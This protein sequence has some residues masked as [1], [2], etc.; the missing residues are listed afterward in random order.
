MK[1]NKSNKRNTVEC[2][3]NLQNTDSSEELYVESSLAQKSKDQTHPS[4]WLIFA[5]CY[6]V[7]AVYSVYSYYNGDVDLY[8]KLGFLSVG[9]FPAGLIV[10]KLL[11]AIGCWKDSPERP[12]SLGHEGP[13]NP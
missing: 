4:Y 1:H 8:T 5:V 9:L 3:K 7:V 13:G 11:K 12:G 10:N 2:E 6:I